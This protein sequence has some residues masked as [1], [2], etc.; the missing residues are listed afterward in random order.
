MSKRNLNDLLQAYQS[1]I[2]PAPVSTGAHFQITTFLLF[3]L[4]GCGGMAAVFFA[5]DTDSGRRVVVK[6][7]LPEKLYDGDFARLFQREQVAS[8]RLGMHDNIV[9][10]EAFGTFA[11]RT[12][13][14]VP[15]LVLQYISGRTLAEKIK[16][17][18]Y[19]PQREVCRIGIELCDA[20]GFV[21]PNFTHRDIKPENVLLDALNG[22]S[23]RLVDFGL[24]ISLDNAADPMSQ[25]SGTPG[26]IAPERLRDPARHR[27]SPGADLFSLGCLLYVATTGSR[28]FNSVVDTISEAFT[29]VRPSVV[30]K[31]IDPGLEVLIMELISRHPTSRPADAF[32]VKDRLSSILKT[33][34]FETDPR[35]PNL[36]DPK[37]VV[38]VAELGQQRLAPLTTGISNVFAENLGLIERFRLSDGIHSDIRKFGDGIQAGSLQDVRKNDPEQIAKAVADVVLELKTLRSKFLVIAIENSRL[39]AF[40]GKVNALCEKLMEFR[41]SLERFSLGAGLALPQ[42]GKEGGVGQGSLDASHLMKLESILWNIWRKLFA[43]EQEMVTD[44]LFVADLLASAIHRIQVLLA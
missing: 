29:L 40:A 15:F 34:P 19:L 27:N 36:S 16:K 22:E 20:L 42:E 28:A 37:I 31:N 9:F 1:H 8:E 33:L 43:Q 14:S 25:V 12:G 32:Q 39:P 30:R 10:F 24:A 13:R 2:P 6:L 11:A 21:H 4:L 5:I 17:W 44:Q 41:Q 3:D 35:W 7:P 23:V 38:R 26:Y 18:E